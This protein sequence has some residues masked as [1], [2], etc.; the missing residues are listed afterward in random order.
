MNMLPFGL[1]LL[2]ASVSREMNDMLLLDMDMDHHYM[3]D[4]LEHKAALPFLL[5]SQDMDLV[6][7]V[8]SVR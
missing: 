1:W 7:D 6:R 2:E 3:F 8:D 5:H 4:W